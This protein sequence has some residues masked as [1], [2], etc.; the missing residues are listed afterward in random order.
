MAD[1]THSPVRSPAHQIPAR[2]SM[3]L[4][5]PF[6]TEVVMCALMTKVDDLTTTVASH[7]AQ[8]VALLSQLVQQQLTVTAAAPRRPEIRGEPPRFDG[9]AEVRG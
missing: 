6:H 9:P 8:T 1:A 7:Q 5:A 3:L 4:A 2:H